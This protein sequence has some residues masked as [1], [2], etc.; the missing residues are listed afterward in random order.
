MTETGIVQ[1]I[2]AV[3]EAA[4]GVRLAEGTIGGSQVRHFTQSSCSGLYSTCIRLQTGETL[5]GETEGMTAETDGTTGGMTAGMTDH[6]ATTASG[7][8]MIETDV[9][10]PHPLLVVTTTVPV[11]ETGLLDA[12]QNATPS[13]QMCSLPQVRPARAQS[14]TR[15]VMLT[16]RRCR[17]CSREFGRRDVASR[18]P[19]RLRGPYGRRC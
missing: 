7:E 3:V 12:Y 17:V 16:D 9:V 13:P 10:N 2:Q 18:S 19:T 14:C 8:N 1:H 5:T 11:N 4:L 15:P 6:D